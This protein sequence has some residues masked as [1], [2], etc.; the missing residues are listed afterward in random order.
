VAAAAANVKP[1]GGT[2]DDGL[3]HTVTYFGIQRPAAANAPAPTSP[4]TEWVAV[5]AQVCY[6]PE[7]ADED[8]PWAWS[9]LG[10]DGEVYGDTSS[11]AYPE[12][13]SPA[14]PT[15]RFTPAKGQCVRGWIVYE[16]PMGVP[17]VNVT[18]MATE[19]DLPVIW[20]A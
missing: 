1:P 9:L 6:G 10:A 8:Q 3:G 15:G 13:P 14:F 18:Y 11:D 16:V 20:T 12:F 2:F 5:D 7:A 19:A 17:I 4:G